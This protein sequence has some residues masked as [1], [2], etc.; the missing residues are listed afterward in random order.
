LGGR[1]KSA[2]DR[3]SLMG[4]RL[5]FCS[6][7]QNELI[8]RFPPNHT[9]RSQPCDSAR[10]G[11]TIDKHDA[12]FRLRSAGL[13]VTLLSNSLSSTL[14]SMLGH[15]DLQRP[16][17]LHKDCV[18]KKIPLIELYRDRPEAVSSQSAVFWLTVPVVLPNLG[19][20]LSKKIIGILIDTMSTYSESPEVRSP[21]EQGLISSFQTLTHFQTQRQ[22]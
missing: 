13:S 22:E 9:A 2:A 19:R 16:Y 4:E 5:D 10:R 6:A 12:Y 17:I 7:Y 18:F 14:Q 11:W 3:S 1:R 21:Q 20:L 8:A 15:R